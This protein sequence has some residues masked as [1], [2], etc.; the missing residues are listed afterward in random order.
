ML[1]DICLEEKGEMPHD[2]LSRH[3][4]ECKKWSALKV[5]VIVIK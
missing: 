5:I 3:F 4:D 1:A 2:L